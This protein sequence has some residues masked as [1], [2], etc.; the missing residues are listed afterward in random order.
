MIGTTK[1]PGGEKGIR[2][3]SAA[4]LLL[5]GVRGE[6]DMQEAWSVDGGES[7]GSTE[8]AEDTMRGGKLRGE[9]CSKSDLRWRV[10]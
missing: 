5:G 1:T 9:K 2:G 3:R 6:L 7:D 4:I 8:P 10:W